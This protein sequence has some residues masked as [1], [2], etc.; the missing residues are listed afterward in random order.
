MDDLDELQE[1]EIEVVQG[2]Q[3]SSSPAMRPRRRP[4]YIRRS[5]RWPTTSLQRSMARTLSKPRVGRRGRYATLG[6][7]PVLS[8]PDDTVPPDC[9]RRARVSGLRPTRRRGSEG[10]GLRLVALQVSKEALLNVRA[11][12]RALI[13]QPPIRLPKR[14]PKVAPNISLEN[15]KGLSNQH[16]THL[17]SILT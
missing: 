1:R 7:S 12:A 13:T 3:L 17:V 2:T 15:P 6:I 4:M 9:E 16:V 14:Y 5:S 10:Q 11:L 8:C